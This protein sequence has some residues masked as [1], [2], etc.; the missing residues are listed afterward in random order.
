MTGHKQ[1]SRLLPVGALLCAMVSIQFGA[2][3]AKG[4]YPSVGAE[5][6]T[7]LRMVVAAIILTIVMR[8]W[9][10]ALTWRKA[11]ALLAYGLAVAT[12]CL[13]FYESIKTIPL[14][15][16]VAIEFLG[17][18][19][20]ATLSSR[21]RL[22]FVWIVLA[23]AG[24]AALSL[25]FHSGIVLDPRG[26]LF[27]LGAAT[28]W[29]IYIVVGPKA[30][31]AAGKYATALGMIIAAMFVL[32]LG[33]HHAG[34]ALLAPGILLTAI[35]VGI[36][37]SAL[38]FSLEMVALTRLSPRVYGIMTSLEPAIGALMGL[39]LLHE[40][41]THRQWSGIAAVMAAAAGAAS[42]ARSP[43]AIDPA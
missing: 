10:A 40:S 8:P 5:G 31:K 19:A 3:L 6:A 35:G 18:L 4:L 41:L 37:S 11:P 42:T 29:A 13:M 34:A 27:A 23:A 24:L 2:S 15:I 39:A 14:G 28:F 12:M 36:F 38:P 17:P 25:P 21:R 20:I 43:T 32:P 33:I 30:G 1:A 26:V 9:R 16:A 7:A 22:D